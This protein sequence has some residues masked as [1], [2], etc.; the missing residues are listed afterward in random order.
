[1]SAESARGSQVALDRISGTAYGCGRRGGP[2]AKARP[3]GEKLEAE[4]EV[5]LG[6]VGVDVGR[7]EIL[8][9]ETMTL[10]EALRTI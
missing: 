1:V 5:A 9:G 2:V 8:G 7:L 6:E 4:F 3:I 10:P